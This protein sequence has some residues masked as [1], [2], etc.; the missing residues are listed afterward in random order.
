MAHEEREAN[1]SWDRI[2]RQLALEDA[3]AKKIT[4]DTSLSAAQRRELI[5][6]IETWIERGDFLDVDDDGDTDWGDDD[7]LNIL[8][9]K[10]GPRGPLGKLGAA[11]HPESDGA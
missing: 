7:V 1:D 6:E 5:Q 10:L 4:A 2:E 8:V 11:A 9:R 3:L